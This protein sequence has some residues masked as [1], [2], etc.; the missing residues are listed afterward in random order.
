MRFVYVLAYVAALVSAS[1][2]ARAWPE[3]GGI[4]TPEFLRQGGV[5]SVAI[6]PIDVSLGVGT[7]VSEAPDTIGMR[8][9]A[10][11]EGAM[12]TELLRRGYVPTSDEQGADAVLSLAG[13][14]YA[15]QNDDG[16]KTALAVIG[17]IL[18]VGIIV[19]ALA[20]RGHG[21]GHGHG[22]GSGA[23]AHAGAGGIHHIG[24]GL[25]H[26]GTHGWHHFGRPR[27]GLDVEIEVPPGPTVAEVPPDGP[28]HALLE[29]RLFDRRTGELLWKSQADLPANPGDEADV[30]ESVAR[31]A[32]SLPPAR[33]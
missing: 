20:S 3:V 11:A 16:A 24:G 31:L 4:A 23:A 33:Y 13:F 8:F 32:A 14:A 5:R 27:V 25:A 15:G 29:L 2:C 19:V 10:A 18:I 7:S 17:I 6:V 9:Q 21:G 28:S 1:G 26:T 30:R 22:G 12:Q